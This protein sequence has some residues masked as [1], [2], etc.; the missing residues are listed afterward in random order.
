[1]EGPTGS[2][3]DCTHLSEIPISALDVFDIFNPHQ[4][5][6]NYMN[7]LY[8][9]RHV[10]KKRTDLLQENHAQQAIEGPGARRNARNTDR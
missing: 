8:G 3:T 9:C 5:P 7:G 10:R 2:R 1:M 6:Q 4:G